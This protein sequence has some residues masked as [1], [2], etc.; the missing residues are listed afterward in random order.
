MEANNVS[1]GSTK[2][3]LSFLPQEW[4][5][6]DQ[7]RNAFVFLCL[8]A[9]HQQTEQRARQ[10]SSTD[11]TTENLRT[12]N[13]D[14]KQNVSNLWQS[15]RSSTARTFLEQNLSKKLHISISRSSRTFLEALL[16][17]E[18]SF[19]NE[20]RMKKRFMTL[21]HLKATSL[22]SFGLPHSTES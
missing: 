16:P 5:G 14:K 12:E 4:S 22:S 15:S 7:V 21:P 6:L 19:G 11:D 8:L 3:G 9:P 2:D 18:F 13:R 1:N 10:R 20:E 17:E